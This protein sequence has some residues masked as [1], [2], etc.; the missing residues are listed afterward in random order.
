[1]K[2]NRNFFKNIRLI[3]Y[4]YYQFKEYYPLLR[5]IRG[6]ANLI[7]NKGIKIKTKIIIEGNN[8]TI[9]I[10]E[11]VVLKHVKIIIK[12]NNHLLSINRDSFI[13]G[14]VL[15]F[16]DDRCVINI[17]ERTFI[18][19]TH[20]AVTED[21]SQIK[22][23]SDSMISSH[24]EIRTGDSHSIINNDTLKRIN[25]AKNVQIGDHVWIASDVKIMKGVVIEKDTII[26]AGSIVTKSFPANV[27]IGGVPAQIIKEN[28][29]WDKSRI[30][31]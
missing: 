1:M 26:S 13:S 12:G 7:K 29:T 24:V 23:G 11:G 18:G 25:Y 6:S 15:W 28:V 16:E 22:I 31:S 2:Y 4:L 20:I 21:D 8:N 19:P 14:T 17:G 9:L 10:G 3:R 30:K 27:L 5:P